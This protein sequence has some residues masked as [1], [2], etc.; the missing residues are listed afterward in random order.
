MPGLPTPALV[1]S[2]LDELQRPAGSAAQLQL[3]VQPT[4]IVIQM[5]IT[6]LL[7]PGIIIVALTGTALREYWKAR[8]PLRAI[9]TET[10]MRELMDILNAEQ[11]ARVDPE[12]LRPLLAKKNRLDCGEDGWGNLLLIERRIRAGKEPLYVIVS[13]GRDGR[14][15]TC[16]QKWVDDWND[17][18]VLAGKDWLQVWVNNPEALRARGVPPL[19][20]T[21]RNQQ[22]R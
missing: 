17:D 2:T 3:V 1:P 22:A 18:A 15:G 12:S 14:R 20:P 4:P 7:V 19:S 8:E 6:I 5:K 13:L 16:C 9:V 21:R 10:R 11:P